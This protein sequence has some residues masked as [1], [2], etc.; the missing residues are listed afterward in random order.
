M[1]TLILTLLLKDGSVCQLWFSDI[2]FKD[3]TFMEN[4]KMI[5]GHIPTRFY[6][7]YNEHE[8]YYGLFFVNPS[9]F[10]CVWSSA[11][12]SHQGLTLNQ[13]KSTKDSQERV[14][15]VRAEIVAADPSVKMRPK[16]FLD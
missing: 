1:V 2:T 15:K 13:L 12:G 4:D 3:T 9:Y 8:T 6:F 5:T 14:L 7:Y 16:T 11:S 10:S